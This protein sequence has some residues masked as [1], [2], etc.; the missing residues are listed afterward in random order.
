VIRV[1]PDSVLQPR[2]PAPGAVGGFF[3]GGFLGAKI[4]GPCD[5]DDPGFKGF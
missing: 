5:C 1:F 4:E 2:R 3:A